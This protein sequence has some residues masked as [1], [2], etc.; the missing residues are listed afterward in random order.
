MRQTLKKHLLTRT[1]THIHT[2]PHMRLL[3][4]T[5]GVVNVAKRKHNTNIHARRASSSSTSTLSA[6]TSLSSTH[7]QSSSH[8]QRSV[9]VQQQQQQR[10]R[11][12]H[13]RSASVGRFADFT[14]QFRAKRG[15]GWSAPCAKR[16]TAE[17]RKRN[18]TQLS[19]KFSK[20]KHT[21]FKLEKIAKINKKKKIKLKVIAR[22]SSLINRVVLF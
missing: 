7:R 18:Q 22:M 19:R 6:S 1:H 14:F 12:H 2:H 10:R 20:I 8:T 9:C 11:R 16:Q 3:A 21:K 4:R 17:I 13:C 5:A 15:S